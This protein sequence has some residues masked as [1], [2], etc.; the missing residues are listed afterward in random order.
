MGFSIS[1]KQ[2]LFCK[3]TCVC[4]C[5]LKLYLQCTLQQLRFVTQTTDE[6]FEWRREIIWKAWLAQ[7]PFN[8]ATLSQLRIQ[9]EVRKGRVESSSH[10]FNI[11]FSFYMKH[12]FLELEIFQTPT[13]P[14]FLDPPSPFPPFFLLLTKSLYIYITFCVTYVE[15]KR[16]SIINFNWI[17]KPGRENENIC[18][19]KICGMDMDY[20][21]RTY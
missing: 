17:E 11:F 20:F 2:Y 6:L 13:R 9:G 8:C 12:V 4:V 16:F 10:K 5:V 3:C 18:L 14:N 7:K 19:C 1:Y 21:V 15:K